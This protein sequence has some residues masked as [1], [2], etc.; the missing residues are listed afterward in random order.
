MRLSLFFVLSLV[1]VSVIAAV[2]CESQETGNVP[3]AAV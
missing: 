3:H 1:R 2:M